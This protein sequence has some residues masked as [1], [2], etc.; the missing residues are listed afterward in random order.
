MK[1]SSSSSP[2]E[3]SFPFFCRSTHFVRCLAII[4]KLICKLSSRFISIACF[5]LI[6]FSLKMSTSGSSFIIVRSLSLAGWTSLRGCSSC[7]LTA[8]WCSSHPLQ[9]AFQYLYWTLCIRLYLVYGH[10]GHRCCI[11][12]ICCHLGLNQPKRYIHFGI[13]VSYQRLSLMKD[14]SKCRHLNCVCIH[15]FT[16][17]NNS[18]TDFWVRFLQKIGFTFLI[19]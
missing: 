17:P 6:L 3:Y 11:K 15:P 8:M 18:V 19:F 14:L 12:K 10:L 5:M 16:S 4:K 2:F 9:W 1:L 7:Q 13:F